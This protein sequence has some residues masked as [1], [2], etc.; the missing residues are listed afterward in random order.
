MPD[1]KLFLLDAMAL[2]YRAHF[3]FLKAPRITSKGLN[4]SC[5]F[6][7]ANALLEVIQKEKP[8]HLGVAFDLPGGTFRNNMFP[9]YK[10]NRQEQPEDITIAIPYVKKLVEAMD[11]P[12]L[13]LQ[14]YEADDVI[15]TLAK[16]A[17]LEGFEVY[18]MTPDKDYGQLVEEHIYLYKPAIGG[19][20][21]EVMGINE[22]CSR[23]GIKRVDQVVDILGLMGDAVDNIPG[24]QGVGEKTAAKLIAEYDTVENLLANSEKL[25]GKLGDSVRNNKEIALLSKEL[26]KIELNVPIDFDGDKLKIMPPHVDIL[27]SL[28]DEL[29]FRTL[30]KRLLPDETPTTIQPTSVIKSVT[31][32]EKKSAIGAKS[33]QQISMFE[34]DTSTNIVFTDNSEDDVLS[35]YNSTSKDT[36]D[37]VVHEYHLID[38]PELRKSLIYYLSQQDEF[39][40][41]TETTSVDAVDAE[42]VGMSFAYRK[43]EAYYIPFP[44]NQQEAY[45]IV[46]EF[47]EVFENEEI[48]KIGQN[49]KYDLMILQ[50]YNVDVKGKMYDT[51]L[52][53]YIIEPEQRHGMDYMAN[54]YLNYDPVSIE[55]LIGKKG[56][57]Q[58]T[59][60]E[61]DLEKVK[62]YAA[63]DADITL[64]LKN[65]LQ[66]R[67]STSVQQ[68]KLLADVEMPLVCVLADME[69][70]GVRVSVDTLHEM[71]KVL[72]TDIQEIQRSI[73]SLAGGEFNVSSPKQLGEILF[74]R[75]RLDKNAKKTKTGQYAT[76]ED[77]LSKLESEHEIVRKILDFRELIKLK[78]TYVDALPALISKKTGR[79]HTSY[80]QAVAATGRLSSTNPN[81]QNIPIRTVRGREI[82]K[83]FIPRDENF[84]ILSADYSQIELRIMA[85]FSEDDSML[86]AFNKGIDIHATTASKVFKV[87]LDQVTSDMRRKAKMV[88]FGIIYGISAF[89]LAQRLSIPRGE[90]KE[91]IDSYWAEFPK[92]KIFMDS[93]INKARETKYVETILG[94]R[95]YLRDI[96]SQNLVDRGFAERNAINAPIQ[97]SAADMIKVAMINI[98][99]F[100]KKEKLK[101][102]MILQVH[103]ELVFDAHQ[104]EIEFLKQKVDELMCT[105]IPLPVKMETG[106][107]VGKNWLEAH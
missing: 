99:D 31:A 105:A 21:V 9:E 100:L 78:S 48:T 101:S 1:K 51:M 49:I 13:S 35:G 53:H 38:T 30:R 58:L 96:N 36:I 88:N 98:H 76:G 46:Q 47:K 104:S 15:G 73:Y 10:A 59:M 80:N 43:G 23:W 6:G 19:K 41:D 71:S 24:I 64:Q 77:V 63:E 54:V 16:K 106:M 2:I 27:S 34:A 95:R 52:A 44:E 40:F 90:A 87:S 86:N 92:I 8:T 62:E 107:G 102:K 91:I 103:D 25:T 20:D 85:A 82:R 70:S 17:A 37:T 61:A 69:M 81:L 29:E 68:E 65:V 14:G 42:I 22:V 56:K 5:V 79:I 4:T 93:A 66:P 12:C 83:A 18:M 67:L 60:R 89:G 7:F 84:A 3:A 55:T 28:L 97:G 75:L 72:D 32:G 94:R 74:E 39:C 26:A 45:Q 57:S 11:I 33:G 50:N